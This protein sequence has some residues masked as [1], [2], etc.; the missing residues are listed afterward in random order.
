MVWFHY[1][2]SEVVDLGSYKIHVVRFAFQVSEVKMGT[3][4]QQTLLY[5]A[6]CG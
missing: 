1:V 6:G 5:F 3:V 4:N 2:H